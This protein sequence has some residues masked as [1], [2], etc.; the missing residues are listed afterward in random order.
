MKYNTF[1]EFYPKHTLRGFN[2]SL[3]KLKLS[4][5]SVL[6]KVKKWP[7]IPIVQGYFREIVVQNSLGISSRIHSK[8]TQKSHFSVNWEGR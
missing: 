7:W 5:E 1:H 6:E 8:E 2:Y 3:E 4:S